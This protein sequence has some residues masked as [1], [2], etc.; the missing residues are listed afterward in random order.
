MACGISGAYLGIERIPEVWQDKLENRQ[1]IHQLALAL[2]EM[3][4]TR[5][6]AATQN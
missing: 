2:A 6:S 1:H 4:T 5:G 3:A